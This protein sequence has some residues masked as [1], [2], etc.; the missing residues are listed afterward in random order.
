MGDGPNQ[1][2]ARKERQRVG[3]VIGNMFVDDS[4]WP[5]RSA[6]ALEEVARM[7]ETFCGF[8][9]VFIHKTKSEYMTVNGK[10]VQ[11]RWGPTEEARGGEA[12][13]PGS[14]AEPKENTTA[15]HHLDAV[16]GLGITL[17]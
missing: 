9:K 10:G 15:T 7:H 11:V 17:G 5:T 2:G 14:E 1:R 4:L 8:H 3:E 13:A 16:N 12:A 6:G